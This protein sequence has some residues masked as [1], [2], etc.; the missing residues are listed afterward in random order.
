MTW[1]HNN[2]TLQLDLEPGIHQQ[3]PIS[4]EYAYDQSPLAIHIRDLTDGLILYD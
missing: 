2:R 1:I 3:P 4:V